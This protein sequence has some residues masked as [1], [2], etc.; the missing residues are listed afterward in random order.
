[1][2]TPA[3]VLELMAPHTTWRMQL[4]AQCQGGERVVIDTDNTTADM[5]GGRYATGERAVRTKKAS[6]AN[7]T[8]LHVVNTMHGGTI[9]IGNMD[10]NIPILPY[11]ASSTNDAERT[12]CPA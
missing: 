11:T 10:A 9:S 2:Y 8:D 12:D 4:L 5:H 1:V 3:E 6:V 7:V